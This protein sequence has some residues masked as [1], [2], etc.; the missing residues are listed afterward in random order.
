[1]EAKY[2]NS[3]VIKKHSIEIYKNIQQSIHCIQDK[4]ILL[5]GH[6]SFMYLVCNY[7]ELN[8]SQRFCLY[9]LGKSHA[10]VAYS[11]KE[12]IQ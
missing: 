10:F 12:K 4:L 1:M 11:L 6:Y 2:K 9:V 5:G 3:D 8:K 7:R